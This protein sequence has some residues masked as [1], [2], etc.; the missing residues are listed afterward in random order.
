MSIRLSRVRFL[1][2]LIPSYLARESAKCPVD[3]SPPLA[4]WTVVVEGAGCCAAHRTGRKARMACFGAAH[5]SGNQPAAPRNLPG[6]RGV[7]LLW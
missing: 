2:E 6:R 7:L 4:A 5:T 3:D 1:R